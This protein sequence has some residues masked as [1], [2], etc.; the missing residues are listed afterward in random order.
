MDL[1]KL[2]EESLDGL[3]NNR[4]YGGFSDPPR[5]DFGPQSN[6]SGYNFP[7]QKGTPPFPLTGSGPEQT[8][9]LPWPLPTITYDLSDGFVYILAAANKIENCLKLNKSLSKEQIKKLEGLSEYSNKI[10]KAIKNL[11]AK[12]NFH[13]D[14]SGDLP[15]INPMQEIPKK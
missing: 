14:L 6:Q 2:L 12:I 9:N 3:Y 7:Y 5:K 4:S 1:N 15:A 13:M 8:S 11:D 10:L